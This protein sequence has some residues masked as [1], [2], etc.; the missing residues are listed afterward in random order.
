MPVVWV[1]SVHPAPA[2]VVHPTSMRP[3]CDESE[4]HAA[5]ATTK[6]KTQIERIDP[7]YR[8]SNQASGCEQRLVGARGSVR[9]ARR[10]TI[11]GSVQIPLV[12][13][14]LALLELVFDATVDD[15]QRRA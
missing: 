14:R 15:T 2:S 12:F 4:L 7:S 8:K 10:P 9:G 1:S 11:I 5:S 6:T 13:R 3:P